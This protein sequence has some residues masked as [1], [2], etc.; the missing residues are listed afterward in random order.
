MWT[1]RDLQKLLSFKPSTPVLSVYINLDPSEATAEA[2]RLQLKEKLKPF[3]AEATRDAKA[4]LAYF[5]Q[6]QLSFGRGVALFSCQAENFFQAHSFALPLRSTARLLSRPYVKPLAQLLD[7]Y[8]HFGVALIDQQNARLIHLHLGEVVEE[9]NWQ[10]EPVR[11]TKRGGGSQAAGRRGGAA[12][13]SGR[14]EEVAERNL[15]EAANLAVQFFNKHQVRRVILGGTEATLTHFQGELP[16]V[17]RSLVIG[18]V[19]LDISAGI[20]KITVSALSLAEKADA[21]HEDALV[22]RLIT[23]AAKGDEAVITLDETLAAI[24]AGRVQHLLLM[25]GYQQPGYRCSGCSYLTVQS[26][27]EC[28]FCGSSF[29]Q[30]KD[31]VEFAVRSVLEAGAELDVISHNSRFEEAGKIGAFLRY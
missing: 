27:D 28:P 7:H 5:D 19:P 24:Q 20:S 22:E 1:E 11:H 25:E 21:A 13:Q 31:A 6:N 17:W 3:E 23:S 8:G 26:L 10:G 30:I 12:G 2:Q 4:I 15:K 14:S 9:I 18:T 29:D 16:K